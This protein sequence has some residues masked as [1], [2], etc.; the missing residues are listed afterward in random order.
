MYIGPR[1]HAVILDVDNKD[2]GSGMSS[3]PEAFTSTDFLAAV[4]DILHPQGACPV[5]W[6]L[7]KGHLFVLQMY[8]IL[9]LHILCVKSDF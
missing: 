3:P 7:V 2:I 4:L 9:P 1:Y 5:G 6:G 8:I